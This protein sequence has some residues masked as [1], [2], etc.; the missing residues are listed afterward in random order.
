MYSDKFLRVLEIILFY[1]GYYTNH[2]K[3]PGKE[4]YRGITI[5]TYKRAVK[6]ELIL[7]KGI[8]NLTEEDLRIIYFSL[9]W[10]P[11]NF[12]LV[13]N[14][15]VVTELFDTAILSGISKSIK[16]VQ[17]VLLALGEVIV[18]D[19][20]LGPVTAGLINKWSIKYPKQFFRLLNSLQGEFFVSL[21][22][23]DPAT[24]RPFLLGWTR[25]I[26]D[27]EEIQQKLSV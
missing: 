27:Y 24:Y 17:R 25:R 14:L 18:H 8:T 9:Y 23:K 16:I 5:H 10:E 1:E 3:D 6:K 12:E 4:T 11:G 2:S 22:E 19:G 26:Q 13:D 20:I 21:V 7:D 15:P